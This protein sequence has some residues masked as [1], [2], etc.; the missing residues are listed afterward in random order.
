[1]KAK[2]WDLIVTIIGKMMSVGERIKF[3][4]NVPESYTNSIIVQLPRFRTAQYYFH[5]M[6]GVLVSSEGP[7]SYLSTE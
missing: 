7:P 3:G 1:M 5:T 4:A 6:T 2:N